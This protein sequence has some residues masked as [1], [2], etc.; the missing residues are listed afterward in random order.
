MGDR[1]RLRFRV[2]CETCGKKQPRATTSFSVTNWMI[3]HSAEHAAT[4]QAKP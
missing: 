2:T 1:E 4:D 3:Q